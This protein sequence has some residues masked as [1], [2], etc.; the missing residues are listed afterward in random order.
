MIN[1]CFTL[2]FALITAYVIYITSKHKALKSISDSEYW[3]TSPWKWIFEALMVTCGGLLIYISH[4]LHNPLAQYGFLLGGLGFFGV[5]VFARF[6]KNTFM[7]VAHIT[8]AVL[9]FTSLSLTFI[10]LQYGWW[11]GVL[12]LVAVLTYYFSKRDNPDIM[13][14]NVELFLIYTLFLGFAVVFHNQ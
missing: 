11:T 2:I 12:G 8:S 14:W 4:H 5:G 7:K 13:I 10:P 1:L 6:K 9:G 3:L